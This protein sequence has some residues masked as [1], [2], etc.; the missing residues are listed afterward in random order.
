MKIQW[1]TTA[2]NPRSSAMEYDA[3]QRGWRLHAVNADDSETFLSIGSRAAACG[4]R[5]AHGWSRDMFIED[6]CQRCM[7]KMTSLDR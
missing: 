5:P 6:K 1:L 3:G 4:L 7:A 2:P